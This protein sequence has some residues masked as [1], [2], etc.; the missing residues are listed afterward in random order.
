[1]TLTDQ[2]EIEDE[3]EDMSYKYDQELVHHDGMDRY[4]DEEEEK[5]NYSVTTK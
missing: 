3:D 2:E 1:M 4:Q 5:E